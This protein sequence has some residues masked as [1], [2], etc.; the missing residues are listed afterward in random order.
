MQQCRNDD[1]SRDA[2]GV[3]EDVL[4]NRQPKCVLWR[5]QRK[6]EPP[7]IVAE[8][9][10]AAGVTAQ[11]KLCQFYTSVMPWLQVYLMVHGMA[12]HLSI[13]DNARLC[14]QFHRCVRIITSFSASAKATRL[15]GFSAT[16]D[17]TSSAAVLG[18]WFS[19]PAPAARHK[20]NC[21]VCTQS[22]KDHLS[23]TVYCQDMPCMW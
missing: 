11:H 1:L 15:R 13:R 6:A 2:L 17:F 12:P 7:H 14:A 9:L 21:H 5:L 18:S 16:S 19:C 10:A 3:Q 22:H 8:D 20:R 4:T 23:N